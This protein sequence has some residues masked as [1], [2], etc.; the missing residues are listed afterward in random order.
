MAIYGYS[1]VSTAMQANGNSLASQE[2]ELRGRGA[3][4]IYSDSFTGMKLDR[5]KLKNLLKK[6]QEGD[7]L[8]LTKLD[9]IART[10]TEGVKLINDL[11][12]RGVCVHILNIG[13]MDNTCAS[14]LIRSIFL[15]FAEFEHD[16]II[17][18]TREGK[19]IART[20]PGFREGRPK[21]YS[22]EQMNHALELLNDN[23]YT[24][25]ERMTGISKSTLTR[26][27][28][29]VTLSELKK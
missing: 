20:K 14:K 7:T 26:A 15:A 12:E 16:M 3:T 9:R 4:I 23:S 6:L 24:Q 8:M 19:A 10:L 22:R 27:K 5:P 17:E 25:V 21:L 29:E 2:A 28:R 11:I 1:R 13:I 18:R